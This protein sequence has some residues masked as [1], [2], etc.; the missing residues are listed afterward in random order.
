MPHGSR[1]LGLHLALEGILV[2]G[3]HKWILAAIP[4]QHLAPDVP[5]LRRVRRVQAAVEAHYAGDVGAAAASFSATVRRRNRSPLTTS[6]D[7]G[8][9]GRVGVKSAV[10][11]VLTLGRATSKP[12]M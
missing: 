12:T 8:E 1:Y 3:R 9:M 7:R 6:G 5:G 2:L 10:H 11:G 4:D